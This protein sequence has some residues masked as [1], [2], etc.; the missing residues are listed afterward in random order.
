MCFA[1]ATALF[2][3][4]AHIFDT[5]R[6]ASSNDQYF[7]VTNFFILFPE[8]DEFP[9][10]L[11]N[12]TKKSIGSTFV[13][14]NMTAYSMKQ[15]KKGDLVQTKPR[16]S[17]EDK[18]SEEEK[19]YRDAVEPLLLMRAYH[20]PG[21]DWK[22]DWAQYMTNNHPMF[23]ICW[24]HKYHPVKRNVRIAG[25]IGS[26]LF[27]LALT[28]IIYLA[29]VFTD[30]D[31]DTTYV[32]VK[33]NFTTGQ[34]NVDSNVNTLTVSN[35][36]IALWTIGAAVH[37]LY[38]NLIWSLAACTCCMDK[39]ITAEKLARY[40]STGVWLVMLS[41]VVVTAIATFAVTLRAALDNNSS[42][43]PTQVDVFNQSKAVGTDTVG[44]WEVSN[45][46]CCI[47]Y[48]NYNA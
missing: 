15:D 24:H 45:G 37:A 43:E 46:K 4:H 7:S 29:F 38:D 26:I 25:L 10:T 44:V 48:S 47:L 17:S 18:L 11:Q 5:D 35:G 13:F 22:Q 41:V 28:N 3:S 8:R 23:G 12:P 31:S 39:S 27:G 19:A 1:N 32:E 42:D 40:K 34:A 16:W 36:N 33:G 21:N 2:F 30:I 20:L 6:T 9:T 14:V